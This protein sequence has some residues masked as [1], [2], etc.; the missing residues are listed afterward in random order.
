MPAV[1]NNGAVSGRSCQRKDLQRSPA[2]GRDAYGYLVAGLAI[3]ALV[4]PY[5]IG[6]DRWQLAA[7]ASGGSLVCV[8]ALV[9][10]G[11][12]LPQYYAMRLFIGGYAIQCMALAAV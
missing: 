1:E 2:V 5:G 3:P 10:V 6:N 12:L 7:I 9:A 8:A 4:A 11:R